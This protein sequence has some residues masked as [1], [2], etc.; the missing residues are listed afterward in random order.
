MHSQRISKASNQVNKINRRQNGMTMI[1]VMIAAVIIVIAIIG[2]MM[3]FVS[4]RKFIVGEQYYRQAA[5]LA[6]QKF[7]ELKS[8]EYNN[9]TDGDTKEKETFNDI[10]Y[11]IETL[12]E[13]GSAPSP[14]VPKP[15]KKVTVTIS[16]KVTTDN[17][18]AVLVTYIGP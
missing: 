13:P 6:S 7:E 17:H 1:E 11:E 5:Q 18:K 8:K 15:C 4:G 12:V 14:T 16:W 10:T 9:I 3:T 2:T